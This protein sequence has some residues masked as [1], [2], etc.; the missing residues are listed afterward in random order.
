MKLSRLSTADEAID[1][2]RNLLVNTGRIVPREWLAAKN[3]AEMLN[4]EDVHRRI[5]SAV[6]S[7]LDNFISKASAQ[8]STFGATSVIQ[9]AQRSVAEEIVV[10]PQRSKVISTGSQTITRW[11]RIGY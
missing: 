10:P 9:H 8:V 3:T 11:A 4:N 2:I 5:A 6:L 7:R 1:A